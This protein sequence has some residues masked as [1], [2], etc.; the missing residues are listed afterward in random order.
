MYAN[1]MALTTT[2]TDRLVMTR[3]V[4]GGA[5]VGFGSDGE[6]DGVEATLGRGLEAGE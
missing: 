3:I 5:C 4:A 6:G 2:T 1:K